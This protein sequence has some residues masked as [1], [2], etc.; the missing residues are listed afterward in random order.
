M[1]N[2]PER[3]FKLRV[4]MRVSQPRLGGV[5]GVSG[6]TVARWEA[7]DVSPQ[8]MHAAVIETLERL[9]AE[10]LAEVMKSRGD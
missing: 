10:K 4:A 5:L 9:E 7:G 6:R 2:W 3:V 8:K 1:S